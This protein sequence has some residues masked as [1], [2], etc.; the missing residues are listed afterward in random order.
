GSTTTFGYDAINRLTS[1]QYPQN[2]SVSMTYDGNDNLVSS[3][4]RNS[5][6]VSYTYDGN[7]RLTAK[8]I[9]RGGGVIGTTFE[10]YDYDGL[11][12][13]ILAKN[14][15]TQV[16]LQYDSRGLITQDK[17]GSTP[18]RSTYDF[19]GNKTSVDYPGSILLARNYDDVDR[20]RSLVAGS[21][22][23]LS[24]EYLGLSR[25]ADKLWAN[26]LLTQYN[27]DNEGRLFDI[28]HGTGSSISG[29]EYQWDNAHYRT[30][31]TKRHYGNL[32]DNFLYD[33]AHQITSAGI[34]LGN[35]PPSTRAFSFD[36]AS[37][38]NVKTADN[39][40]RNYLT[41]AEHQY[42]NDG[43]D[44]FEYDGN[45]NL[46]HHITTN[47]ERKFSYD[48]MNRLMHAEVTVNGETTD[49]NFQYDALGRRI[50]RSSGSSVTKYI[51]EG[52]QVVQEL[53]ASDAVVRE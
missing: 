15:D 7:N 11:D 46:T 13:M 44:Q 10:N 52:S 45:G 20:L 3:L 48:Y 9:V 14:D 34:H 23:V 24:I 49:V 31:E 17:Q 12:R 4:D 2:G 29:F 18:V 19:V 27:Y 32:Q 6:S 8:N 51:Y 50:L 30:R 40:V 38:I 39:V 1:I 35:N 43:V 25:A 53:D 22:N 37:N 26:G 5:N 36:S 47:T 28:V 21:A 42:V 16:E 41:S 33:G